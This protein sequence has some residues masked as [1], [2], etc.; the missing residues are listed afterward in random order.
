MVIGL[1]LTLAVVTIFPCVPAIT[2][3]LPDD[4]GVG[5]FRSISIKL[6]ILDFYFH[7]H[8]SSPIGHFFDML[9][10]YPFPERSVRG[11]FGSLPPEGILHPSN[12]YSSRRSSR[13]QMLAVPMSFGPL[14]H[15]ANEFLGDLACREVAGGGTGDRLRDQDSGQHAQDIN[16]PQESHVLRALPGWTFSALEL[17]CIMYAGFKRIEPGMDIGVDLS[18]E[19]GDGGEA[20]ELFM[21]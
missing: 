1:S 13:F 12:S 7:S 9:I 6:V 2:R 11:V 4:D 5:S 21:Y 14:F 20:D 10:Y 8:T 19:W 16:D 18:E 15:P 3:V 17:V